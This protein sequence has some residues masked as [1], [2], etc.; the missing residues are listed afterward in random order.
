MDNGQIFASHGIGGLVGNILTALFAE[1]AI[2]AYDGTVINGGWLDHHY[3]QLAYHLADS[4]A[5]LAYAFIM[6]V[7][8]AIHFRQDGLSHHSDRRLFSGSCT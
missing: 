3:I 8:T 2:A 5:G 6:T 1:K 4:S 7:S